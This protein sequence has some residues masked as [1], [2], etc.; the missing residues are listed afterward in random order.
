MSEYS[1]SV[2]PPSCK[3]SRELLEE[4]EDY[5]SRKV[6][7]LVIIPPDKPAVGYA[8]EVVIRDSVGEETFGSIK[9][10]DRS[11]FPNDTKAIHLKWRSYKSSTDRITAELKFSR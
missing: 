6:L 7:E 8:H 2:R 3:V 9:D 1:S 10:F 4:L 5:L 11:Y